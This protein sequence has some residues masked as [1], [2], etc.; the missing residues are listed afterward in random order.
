MSPF[1]SI[2]LQY[3]LVSE[4]FIVSSNEYSNEACFAAFNVR[5]WRQDML[6]KIIVVL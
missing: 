3:V 2:L 1:Q 4:L 5:M 6:K